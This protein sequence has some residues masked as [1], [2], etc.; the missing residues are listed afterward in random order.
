MSIEEEESSRRRFVLVSL[1]L[2]LFSLWG[3]NK[4]KNKTK[5]QQL[6]QRDVVG[7]EDRSNRR[8][9]EVG[10]EGLFSLYCFSEKGGKKKKQGK[11]RSGSSVDCRWK[12][13]ATTNASR[14][15]FSFFFLPQARRRISLCSSNA[16]PSNASL[17]KEKTVMSLK[18][19]IF[20]IPREGKGEI[21]G[22]G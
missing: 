5:Q 10:R 8:V 18:Q 6:T 22:G 13:K 1:S 12:K 3:K 21:Q 19:C 17:V 7:E 15:S 16:F 4:T 11:K 2:S 20:L 14:F 9:L